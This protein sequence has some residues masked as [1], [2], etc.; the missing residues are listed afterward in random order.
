MRQLQ[1][2][3]ESDMFKQAAYLQNW[4]DLLHGCTSHSLLP[5]HTHTRKWYG[6]GSLLGC[7]R[8]CVCLLLSLY[9][10]AQ[11]SRLR[12]KGLRL[13]GNQHTVPVACE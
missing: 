13:A 9:A 10:C 1:L 3:H 7:V 2:L 6:D 8:V 11:L 5:G 12:Q 4:T